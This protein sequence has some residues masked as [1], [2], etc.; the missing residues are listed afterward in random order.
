MKIVPLTTEHLSRLYESGEHA[1]LAPLLSDATYAPAL[2]AA[3]PCFA[4]LRD[5]LVVGAAGLIRQWPGRAVAWA[6][7]GRPSGACMLQIHRA[8]RRFLDSCGERRVE[9]AVDHEFGPAHHWMDLLGFKHEC[10]APGYLPDG[11]AA[12]L[13]ALV[14]G[15]QKS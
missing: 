8:V 12:D 11:R 3:G 14:K 5:G 6:L 15:G 1:M 10:L 13:Y 7:L 2:I 9:A 4:A